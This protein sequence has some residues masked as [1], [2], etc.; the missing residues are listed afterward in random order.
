MSEYG[1]GPEYGDPNDT[2]THLRAQAAELAR[3]LYITA[4]DSNPKAHVAWDGDGTKDNLGHA[5]RE[6]AAYRKYVQLAEFALAFAGIDL[7]T[8]RVA[9]LEGGYSGPGE[10]TLMRASAA[11]QEE[12]S[13]MCRELKMS[14]GDVARSFVSPTNHRLLRAALQAAAQGDGT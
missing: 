11:V 3:G 2:P 10:Q 9:E 7:L 1:L 6:D 8:S 4:F 12:W 14:A 13:V 5:K